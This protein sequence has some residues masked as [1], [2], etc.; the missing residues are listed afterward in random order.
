[1]KK[2]YIY[3]IPLI[4]NINLFSKKQVKTLIYIYNVKIFSNFD[5]FSDKIVEFLFSIVS[6]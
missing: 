6:T 3:F 5:I 2:K 4:I 1:M